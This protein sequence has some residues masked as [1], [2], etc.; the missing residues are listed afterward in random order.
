VEGSEGASPF[1][2]QAAGV[3][4]QQQ[5]HHPT[6]PNPALPGQLARTDAVVVVAAAA[7]EEEEV[8]GG[9]SH[10]KGSHWGAE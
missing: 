2:P 9:A 5:N 3:L 6:W 1:L 8:R 7:A 4:T 10:M